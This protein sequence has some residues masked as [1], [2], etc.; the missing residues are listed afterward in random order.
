[1]CGPHGRCTERCDNGTSCL[2]GESCLPSAE[3]AGDG[4]RWCMIGCENPDDC[5]DTL[6]HFGSRTVCREIVYPPSNG[7]VSAMF[8]SDPHHGWGDTGN[9]PPEQAD[10]S[11]G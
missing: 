2:K 8:C 11:G 1:M 4:L 9:D 10:D 6:E 5:D 3:V 7:R